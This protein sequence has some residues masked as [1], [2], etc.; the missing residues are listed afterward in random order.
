MPNSPQP[1]D[2]GRITFSVSRIDEVF[3]DAILEALYG[4]AAD[5]LIRD[6]GCVPPEVRGG[7]SL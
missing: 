2:D 5:M 7:R 1:E 4:L 6:A 3:E